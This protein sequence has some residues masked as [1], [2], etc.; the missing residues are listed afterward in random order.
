MSWLLQIVLQWTSRCLYL[1][2]LE[3]SSFLDISENNFLNTTVILPSSELGPYF[4]LAQELF[5]FYRANLYKKEEGIEYMYIFENKAMIS[6][7]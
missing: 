6:L 4:D 3:F 1:F 5:W 7:F 2:E